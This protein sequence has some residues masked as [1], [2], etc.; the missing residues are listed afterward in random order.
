MGC[1]AHLQ[2]IFQGFIFKL[3]IFTLWSTF[4]LFPYPEY[5]LVHLNLLKSDNIKNS[6]S[7]VPAA[8]YVRLSAIRFDNALLDWSGTAPLRTAY[9]LWC[10]LGLDTQGVW[11]EVNVHVLKFNLL[12]MVVLLWAQPFCLRPGSN[13]VTISGWERVVWIAV[14]YSWRTQKVVWCFSYVMHGWRGPKQTIWD[15]FDFSIWKGTVRSTT[16]FPFWKLTV[17]RRK[18]DIFPRHS[19]LLLELEIV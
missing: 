1:H 12:A 8:F 4:P 17:L 11:L 15:H 10:D 2:G 3:E 9:F 6:T 7:V 18:V 14:A 5:Q 19:K 13:W 16:A